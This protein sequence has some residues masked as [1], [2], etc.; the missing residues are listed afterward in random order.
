MLDN[1]HAVLIIG[2]TSSTVTWMDPDTMQKTT[3][4]IINADRIFKNA[5]Y[6][7]VSYVS[8]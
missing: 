6:V 1:S 8:N 5:G 2:Y 3:T 4:S 7:F